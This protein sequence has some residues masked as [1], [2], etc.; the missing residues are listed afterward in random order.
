MQSRRRLRGCIFAGLACAAGAVAG[1]QNLLVNGDFHDDALAWNLVLGSQLDWTAT[2]EEED[3]PGSGAALA[4]AEL[5][6]GLY[7]AEI[8]QCVA[9]G[10]EQ[11]VHARIVCTDCWVRQD[12]FHD[13]AVA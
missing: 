10:T 6:S 4:T 11:R 12:R 7:Q 13:A 5:A 2:P 9:L 8:Q 3:C 1:A